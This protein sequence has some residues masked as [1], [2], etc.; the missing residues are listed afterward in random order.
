MKTIREISEIEFEE[1]VLHATQPVLVGFVGRGSTPC[2]LFRR[3]LERVADVC[4]ES[5][6]VLAVNLNDSPI[7]GACYGIQYV[8]TLLY[9][10]NG[11]VGAKTVGIASPKEIL[12]QLQSL[13]SENTFATETETQL[14]R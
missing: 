4:G 7:L 11:D 14:K 1:E 3:V 12:A 8:P 9:F 13:S 6:K 5:A 2:R 10:I